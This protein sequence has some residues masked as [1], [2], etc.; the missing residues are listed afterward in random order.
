MLLKRGVKWERDRLTYEQKDQE[1]IEHNL[2]RQ[3]SLARH[4]QG[5]KL[6][7]QLAGKNLIRYS[8]FDNE[9]NK[10]KCNGKSQL[11]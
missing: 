5:L 6:A 10:L 2:E 9:L 7:N 11:T 3:R 8:L 1:T 4:N